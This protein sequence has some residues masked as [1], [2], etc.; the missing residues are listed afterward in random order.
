MPRIRFLCV[1]GAL[2]LGAA[3]ATRGTPDPVVSLESLTELWTDTLRDTDQIGMKATRVSDA[4]EMRIGA[5]LA[6]NV[7]YLGPED[8]TAHYYVDAVGQTVAQ[9]VQRRG[10]RYQFHV[11]GSPAVN[12][13]AIPG[14]QIFVT[15]AMLQFVESEA[16]LAAILG[17]EISH[18][19]LRHSIERYQ[20]EA[21]LRNAGMP[22]AGQIAEIAHQLA[23]F[24]FAH[25]Q[26][27]D[28]DAQG[29]R[30][31][32]ESGYDPEAASA[33]FRRLQAKMGEP[34]RVPAAT[35]AGEVAQSAGVAVEAFFRSH[36]PS[37]ERARALDQMVARQRSELKGKAFYV[38]RA[39]LRERIAKSSRQYPGEYVEMP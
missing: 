11:I 35:P 5:E 13:F 17:H 12:A 8:S 25:D 6:Q 30:M 9:H 31:T 3:V 22:V 1:L 39:N 33:V 26:E 34:S 29:E 37:E 18:V 15:T 36:P 21:K 4:E 14:G 38:G 19:D 7:G 16:E 20:Y 24:G 10:I 28:A 23:T 32:I 27:L 2:I